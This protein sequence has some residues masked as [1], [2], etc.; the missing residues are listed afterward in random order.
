MPPPH[1]RSAWRR[2]Q[3][4][5]VCGA[6]NKYRCTLQ[7]T[8]SS[9]YYYKPKNQPLSGPS[10]KSMFWVADSARTSSSSCSMSLPLF[11]TASCRTGT[12][13]D[14]I[15][16]GASSTQNVQPGCITTGHCTGYC[17]CYSRCCRCRFVLLSVN[18]RH[19]INNFALTFTHFDHPKWSNL[20]PEWHWNGPHVDWTLMARLRGLWNHQLCALNDSAT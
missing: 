6:I 15:R 12:T 7:T 17:W 8:A 19:R 20:S 5:H 14:R 1:N 11:T 9:N 13:R 16:G 4:K 10:I 3:T 2:H 18:N